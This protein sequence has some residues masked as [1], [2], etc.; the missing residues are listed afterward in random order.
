M[1]RTWCGRSIA[2]N[3]RASRRAPI[4]GLAGPVP[5]PR[6]PPRPKPVVKASSIRS[7]VRCAR[8]TTSSPGE[9]GSRRSTT[10]SPRNPTPPNA[11]PPCWIFRQVCGPGSPRRRA[12]WATP[13][14]RSR[15]SRRS[16]KSGKTNDRAPASPSASRS[17]PRTSLPIP[18]CTSSVIAGWREPRTSCSSRFANAPRT[19]INSPSIGRARSSATARCATTCSRT[20]AH[21]SPPRPSSWTRKPPTRPTAPC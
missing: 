9:P 15:R 11:S 8:A 2:T 1:P 5:A 20:T 16:P 10:S 14:C 19:M 12:P 21:S 6:C 18:A 3:S 17:A 13:R 7:F 4:S